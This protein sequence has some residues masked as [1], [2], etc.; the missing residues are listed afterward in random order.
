M[1]EI[2]RQIVK[3]S[4]KRQELGLV[5]R[6]F[7]EDSKKES[8]FL[9][10]KTERIAAALVLMTDLVKDNSDLTK[11]VTTE[12]L[13]MVAKPVIFVD[14][15]LEEIISLIN[16]RIV[17]LRTLISLVQL[18]KLS[19]RFSSMNAD[20]VKEEME[21]II[22]GLEGFLESL[23]GGVPAVNLTFSRGSAFE[24]PK[25]FFHVKKPDNS[26]DYRETKSAIEDN[27]LVPK[28]ENISEAAS[29]VYSERKK[30]NKQESTVV[31]SFSK[32]KPVQ[33]N[34]KQER[35]VKI[36][37]I[38]ARLGKANLRDIANNFPGVSE[39]TIQRDL[40]ALINAGKV[41]TEG[42]RRWTVYL[43]A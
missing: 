40:V 32:N 1:V 41:K 4:D 25:E 18:G 7:K 8:V 2:K 6:A 38:V 33:N 5:L 9:N 13:E 24:I 28:K 11:V 43:L 16:Y 22:S 37:G 14:S 12:V 23:L 3:D 21:K 10:K 27:A 36:V 26:S 17:K 34:L 35:S 19:G 29:G 15:D 42:K 30:E 20:L 31:D 39:K